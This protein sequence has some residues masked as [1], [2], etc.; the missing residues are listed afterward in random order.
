MTTFSFVL[1]FLV[2]V[3]IIKGV[4]IVPQGEE[5]VVERLG[6]FAG[7]LSPGLHVITQCLLK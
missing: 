6:K 4:R 2:V 7:V 3:A 5:W 1:I